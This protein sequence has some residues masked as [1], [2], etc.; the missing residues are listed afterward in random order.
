MY[1]FTYFLHGPNFPDF[2]D[3]YRALTNGHR[4]GVDVLHIMDLLPPFHVIRYFVSYYIDPIF[5]ADVLNF[6][7]IY[8][9]YAIICEPP[10]N[11]TSIMWKAI[12]AVARVSSSHDIR[13]LPF[14][15]LLTRFLKGLTICRE[16]ITICSHE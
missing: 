10:L 1:E 7:H 4:H 3:V 16:D 2:D 8:L 5:S 15:C 11:F 9:I 6:E 12:V 13:V 14:G